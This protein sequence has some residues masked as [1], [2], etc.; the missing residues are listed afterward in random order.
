ML[1]IVLQVQ[2]LY[3]M[4]DLSDGVML[5]GEPYGGKTKAWKILAASLKVNYIFSSFNLKREY[6]TMT[7]HCC[8]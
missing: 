5:L 6:F 7:H 2:Q 8:P 1:I 3:D 4:M